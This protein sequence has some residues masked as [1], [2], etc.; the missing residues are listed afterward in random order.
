MKYTEILTNDVINGDG[1]RVT[2]FVSGCSLHCPNC[3]NPKL[4]SKDYGKDFTGETVGQIA[5]ALLPKYIDGLTI[6]GGHPLDPCNIDACTKLCENIKALHPSKTIW[7]YTGYVYE[8]IKNL[9]IL[10]YIDV[11]VVYFYCNNFIFKYTG[12][13]INY[14][15]ILWFNLYSVYNTAHWQRNVCFKPC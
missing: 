6:T 11:L 12:I 1:W 7:L 9:E 3:H 4:Q 13:I 14:Q 2:L 10:D 5:D 8:D 15:E